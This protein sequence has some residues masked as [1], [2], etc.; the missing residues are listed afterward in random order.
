[1]NRTISKTLLGLLLL[2]PF[3]YG[4][5]YGAEVEL[6]RT[7]DSAGFQEVLAVSG[8]IYIAGQPDED[9]LARA[10]SLG[11]TTVVN[12]R[13]HRETDNR[14]I[15]PYDEQ[16]SVAELGMKYVHIP[17]GGPDT[18]YGPEAV[19]LFAEAM[20]AAE[21]KVLLHCTVAWRASH[22]WTA[23]LVKHKGFDL[24]EAVRHGRAVNF[25]T[26]PLEGFLDKSLTMDYLE[27]R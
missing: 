21:G 23:Y 26:L 2:S 20:D 9:G 16:A 3:L 14:S 18:P 19:D 27:P 1:M 12:L 15:V 24:Q 11:V 6:P 13:T 5:V 8:D 7:L 4:Q 10:K 22:L 25:G 17:L